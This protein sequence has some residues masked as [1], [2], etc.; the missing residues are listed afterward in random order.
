MLAALISLQHTAQQ[1]ADQPIAGRTLA[2]RQLDFA[3]ACGAGRVIVLG[4]GAS[5]SAIALRHH[6]EAA[7][8]H[9]TAVSNAHALAGTLQDQAALLVLQPGL[10]PQDRLMA[11][12]LKQDVLK[13]GASILTLPGAAGAAAGFERIDLERAW[14]GALVMPGHLAERLEELPEDSDAIAALLRIGL[15]GRLPEHRLE[16]QLLAN[17][18]WSLL[19]AGR[20]S[21]DVSRAWI[22]RHL[23]AVPRFAVSRQ[24]AHFL[25][26]RLAHYMLAAPQSLLALLLLAAVLSAGSLVAA[27][28]AGAFSAMAFGLIALLQPVLHLTANVAGLR[29]APFGAAPFPRLLLYAPDVLLLLCGVLTIQGGAHHRLFAPAVLLLALHVCRSEA[30]GNWA[31]L[32]QDRFLLAAAFAIAALGGWQEQAFMLATLALLSCAVAGRFSAI[33]RD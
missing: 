2:V 7:K 17:G 24:L 32:L 16:D 29:Q 1:P 31:A 22:A 18:N 4:S 19:D 26:S 14:A 33:T 6:A 13:Q 23:P 3:R 9:F 20:S 25:A 11:E 10:L 28:A 21:A 8:L 12:M 5:D 30:I 27:A 15:Q